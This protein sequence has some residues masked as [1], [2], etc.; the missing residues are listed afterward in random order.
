MRCNR[1][2]MLSS[3]RSHRSS[4]A[5][6]CPKQPTS[7]TS[8]NRMRFMLRSPPSMHSNRVSILDPHWPASTG[9]PHSSSVGCVCVFHE[10]APIGTLSHTIFRAHHRQMQ[11]GE[12]SFALSRLR[13][14]PP[15]TL[16]GW[17]SSE[18]TTVPHVSRTLTWHDFVKIGCT[19]R[20]QAP[21]SQ[22]RCAASQ[23]CLGRRT[24]S[25]KRALTPRILRGTAFR[26]YCEQVRYCTS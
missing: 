8:R 5:H 24:D 2:P 16:G 15:L 25:M 11:T 26:P 1:P 19:R 13:M 17:P 6:R 18:E 14:S 20:L 22:D 12:R 7:N 4:P 10:S 9:L 23:Q 3:Q 21:Y